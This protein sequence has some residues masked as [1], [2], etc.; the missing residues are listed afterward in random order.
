MCIKGYLCVCVMHSFHLHGLTR[1]FCLRLHVFGQ[2]SNSMFYALWCLA[3]SVV[4]SYDQK[5]KKVNHELHNDYLHVSVILHHQNVFLGPSRPVHCMCCSSRTAKLNFPP[6]RTP[7]P[8]SAVWS[9]AKNP[10]KFHQNL[11]L[12][13]IVRNV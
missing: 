8:L 6:P 9:N 11:I 5:S 3:E 2:G 12:V 10:P 1:M 13:R 7:T 4:T